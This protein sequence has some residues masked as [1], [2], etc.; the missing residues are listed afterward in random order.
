MC[1]ATGSGYIIS[2]AAMAMYKK[3]A[4]GC[5]NKMRNNLKAGHHCFGD[6]AVSICM[7]DAGLT[8]THEPGLNNVNFDHFGRDTHAHD[9]KL[10][11]FHNNGDT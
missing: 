3:N 5:M 4:G 9:K 11:S 1:C 2:S 8:L 6:M 10:L 7:H